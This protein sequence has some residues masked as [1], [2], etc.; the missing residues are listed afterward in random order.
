MPKNH[1]LKILNPV[2]LLFLLL[3]A[4]T[5]FIHDQIPDKVFGVLHGGGGVLFVLLAIAHIGLNWSWI[6]GQYFPKR[7]RVEPAAKVGDAK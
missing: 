2:L 5:G 4:I 7:A 1:A 6:R 3:Q